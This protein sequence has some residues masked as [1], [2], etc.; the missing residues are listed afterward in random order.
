[1]KFSNHLS[2]D[3]IG[4]LIWLT[5]GAAIVYGSWVMDRLD[6]LKIPPATV[7]GLV[8]GL[9]G[10][11]LIIFGLILAL[12]RTDAVIETQSFVVEEQPEAAADTHDEFAWKRLALSWLLCATYGGLLLGHGIHYWILTCAFLALHMLLLDET[13][14][15][16]ARPDTFRLILVALLAPTIATVVTLIFRY[17]FLVRLP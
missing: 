1:M 11:G 14:R 7:P 8:P 16:P 17:V 12:R 3:R 4:G 15:V 5:F 13:E 2:A 9:L 6:S 10:A